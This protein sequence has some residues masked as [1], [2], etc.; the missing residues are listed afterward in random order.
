MTGSSK[1]KSNTRT[2]YGVCFVVQV[3]DL[4]HQKIV[5]SAWSGGIAT[6]RQRG[7]EVGVKLVEGTRKSH[8]RTTQGSI[9]WFAI[10]KKYL[11]HSWWFKF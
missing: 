6:I 4:V 9:D 1:N 3:A 7:F 5:F 10:G 8:K 11:E 2:P